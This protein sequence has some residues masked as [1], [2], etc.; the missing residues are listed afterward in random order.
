MGKKESCPPE[1]KLRESFGFKPS[2]EPLSWR[3]ESWEGNTVTFV[4]P[5]LICVF[6]CGMHVHAMGMCGIQR[7]TS[8]DW[9]SPSTGSVPRIGLR[10]SGLVASVLI[11]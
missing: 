1:G 8:V 10:L 7:T 6:V 4:V 3:W 5:L 11:C 9:F 2:R